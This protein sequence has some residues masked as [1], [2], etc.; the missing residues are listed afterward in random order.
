[1]M[2]TLRS[3]KPLSYPLPPPTNNLLEY[4]SHMH[5]YRRRPSTLILPTGLLRFAY[6]L[7]RQKSYYITSGILCHILRRLLHFAAA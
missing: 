6:Y 7:M 2:A 1:M 4:T 3:P 5:F